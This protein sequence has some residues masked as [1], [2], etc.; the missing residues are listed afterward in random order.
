[1][2]KARPRV[3]VTIDSNTIFRVLLIL[4]GI[5]FL[6]YISNVLVVAF[7]AFI[8]VSAIAPVVD[9]LEKYHLP[10]FLVVFLIYI[11]FITGLFYLLSFLIP[12][13]GDQLRLLSQNLPLYAE[14]LSFLREKFQHF[15]G[16]NVYF[17]QQ[18]KSDFLLNLGNR[19]NENWWNIFSQAGSFV[20]GLVNIIAVF[21][22]AF[23][24]SIQK[25]SVGNFLK[26]FIP[27]QH[28][29]Y[30]VAL[31]ERIQ[32]KM[33]HWLLGQLALNIIMGIFVYVGLSLL[34]VPYA[35]LLA[36]IATVFE[37]VP[38][39]GGILSATLGVLAALSIGPFTSILVLTLY[40]ALQ[41]FQNHLLAPLVMKQ[42]V[43]LNPVAVIL[44]I[45][46]GLKIAGPLGIILAIP[47]TAAL[48][49][50]VSDF[51]AAEEQSV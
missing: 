4:L 24:L 37:F 17:L 16:G 31:V 5:L 47:I 44:A 14:K 35:L 8:I 25:R 3:I 15:L 42:V 18:E 23:F 51:I 12:A 32:Q 41:Q 22:L 48:S 1:M 9:F 7:I 28:E 21:S 40:L 49:V 38:Y 11:L 13:I 33:G 43:G 19:F 30:A 2:T 50:F 46:I 39:I 20:L 34:G 6:Y 10:R 27:K 26:A 36:I 45:L 29:Q